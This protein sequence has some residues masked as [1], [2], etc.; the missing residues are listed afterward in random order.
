MSVIT[1]ARMSLWRFTN[2]V[3]TG[4]SE[5]CFAGD[6]IK[7][8]VTSSTVNSRK[9]SSDSSTSRS[10]ICGGGDVAVDARIRSTFD[11]KNWANSVAVEDVTVAGSGSGSTRGRSFDHS[12]LA[13][14]PH[15]SMA[16]EQKLTNLDWNSTRWLS[17]CVKQLG[18]RTV[19]TR[20]NNAL[21]FRSSRST[22]ERDHCWMTLWHP[23]MGSIFESRKSKVKFT[24][25]RSF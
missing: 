22:A 6:F 13:L 10:S 1:G 21:H 24:A 5:H 14:P 17:N 23:G 15:D 3:G 9:S 20:N 12:A 7:T 16:A 2:Q 11:V 8:R 4:S 25:S 19:V 18:Q